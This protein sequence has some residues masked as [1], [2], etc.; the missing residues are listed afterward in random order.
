MIEQTFITEINKLISVYGSIS[1]FNKRSVNQAVEIVSF[2]NPHKFSVVKNT[3]KNTLSF[4]LT[5]IDGTLP[6]L[7]DKKYMRFLSQRVGEKENLK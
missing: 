5:K 1:Y 7:K 4:Q 3:I 2:D 6:I